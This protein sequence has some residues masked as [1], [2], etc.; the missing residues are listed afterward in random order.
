MK[1]QEYYPCIKEKDFCMTLKKHIQTNGMPKGL[2]YFT[3]MTKP[4][5]IEFK[6]IGVVYREKPK[7]NGILINYCPFC[8][9]DLRPFREEYVKSAEVV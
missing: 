2:S 9:N 8:G 3:I 1:E 6:T 7:D 5:N 4:P